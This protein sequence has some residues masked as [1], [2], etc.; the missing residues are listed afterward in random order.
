MKSSRDLWKPI[1]LCSV[2]LFATVVACG[3]PPAAAPVGGVCGNQ[4]NMSAALSD[5]RTAKEDLVRA[6]HNK[7]GWRERAV[8][9]T[10]VA[11]RE[12]ENGCAVAQ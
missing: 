4:P 10:E 8:Q 1:A 2:A 5:L 11:I 7:G 3:G 12:T 9:Q 6:E